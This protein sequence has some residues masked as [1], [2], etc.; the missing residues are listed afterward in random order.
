M[1]SIH[2]LKVEDRKVIFYKLRQLALETHNFIKREKFLRMELDELLKDKFVSK[3]KFITMVKDLK[4]RLDELKLKRQRNVIKA[5]K[6]LNGDFDIVRERFRMKIIN[7]L[8]N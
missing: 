2:E 7:K 4:V 5:R 1:H 6:I 3:E 8:N